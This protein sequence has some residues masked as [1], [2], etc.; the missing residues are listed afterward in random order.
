MSTT[1]T[2]TYSS[3]PSASWFHTMTMAM[4]RAMPTKMRPRM[5]CGLSGRQATARK[6]M[7]SGPITQLMS[8]DMVSMDE[9]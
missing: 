1:S 9:K 8:S 6:N 2:H 3:L 7:R 5:R 4:Q